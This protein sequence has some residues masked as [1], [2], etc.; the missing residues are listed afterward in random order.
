M[1]NFVLWVIVAVICGSMGAPGWIILLV[2][3]LLSVLGII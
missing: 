1:S 3:F 2:S